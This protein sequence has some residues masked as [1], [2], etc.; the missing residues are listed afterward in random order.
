MSILHC[1]YQNG[2]YLFKFFALLTI[3]CIN[4]LAILH[5]L[6]LPNLLQLI[7]QSKRAITITQK[8]PKE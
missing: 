4:L 5:S 6:L 2:K 7:I 8:L 1:M 3:L